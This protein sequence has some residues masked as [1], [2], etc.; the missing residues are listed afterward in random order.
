MNQLMFR[1]VKNDFEALLMGQAALA[2]GCRIV[3]IH[4]H[5]L[6]IGGEI[7]ACVF[8]VWIEYPDSVAPDAVDQAFY[9][10]LE[11]RS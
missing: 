5:D 8:C 6:R 9:K 11:A 3:S 1:H 4:P 10:R 2:L 7:L